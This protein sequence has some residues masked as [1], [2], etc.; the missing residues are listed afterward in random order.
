[1]EVIAVDRLFRS[2]DRCVQCAYWADRPQLNSGVRRPLLSFDVTE[3]TSSEIIASN[4]K[5]SWKRSA[6]ITGLLALGVVL[7]LAWPSPWPVFTAP[8]GHQITHVILGHFVVPNE[9]PVLRLRYETKLPLADTVAL[10]NEARDL[11]PRFREDVDRGSYV[12]AAFLA[13]APPTGPCFR[14]RGLCFYKSYGFLAR[15]HDDGRWYFDGDSVP[16]P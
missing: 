10:K 15:K 13:D 12:N 16:L 9:K 8:G 6:W 4:P 5:R 2:S 7:V 14:H 1:M 3:S 11:W